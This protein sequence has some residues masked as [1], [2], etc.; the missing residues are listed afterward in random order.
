[1]WP[2]LFLSG[3]RPPPEP[4]KR[5]RQYPNYE[6]R[7]DKGQNSVDNQV[8]FLLGIA[9]LAD[10]LPQR[11]VIHLDFPNFRADRRHTSPSKAPTPSNGQPPLRLTESWFP[12]G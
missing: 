2:A 8:T 9:T 10:L 4:G 1:M 6:N 5:Y 3:T 7:E 11:A 12:L